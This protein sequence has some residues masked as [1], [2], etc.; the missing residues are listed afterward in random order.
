MADP[1]GAGE[2]TGAAGPAT[3]DE[4]VVWLRNHFRPEAAEGLE[5]SY[6]LD[7]GGPGGGVLR[8]VIAGG[9]VEVERT[10]EADA[11]VVLRLSVAD[12]LAVLAGRANADLLYMEGRLEIEGDLALATRVRTLFRPRA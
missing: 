9:R 4:A 1:A 3:L 5:V 11:D 2:T 12:Y 10:A 6:A 8:L 7:L